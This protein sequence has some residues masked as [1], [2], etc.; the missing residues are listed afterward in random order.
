M[1]HDYDPWRLHLGSVLALTC[2]DIGACPL[3][4]VHVVS[5]TR[6]LAAGPLSPAGFKVRPPWIGLAPAC[7]FE[8]GSGEIWRPDQHLSF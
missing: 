1:L 5:G 7:P 6:L 2:Q 4:G 8:L 3:E